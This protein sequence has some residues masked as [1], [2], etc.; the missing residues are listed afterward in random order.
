MSEEDSGSIETSVRVV[1]DKYTGEWKKPY[2]TQNLKRLY[3]HGLNRNAAKKIKNAGI[4]EDSL[5]KYIDDFSDEDKEIIAK[6]IQTINDDDQLM[7]IDQVSYYCVNWLSRL[8]EEAR[9]GQQK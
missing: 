1:L 9:N 3:Y 6:K 5:K 2:S 4:D 8:F 7:K